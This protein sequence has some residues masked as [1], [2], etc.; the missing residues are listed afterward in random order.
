MAM[1]MK[2]TVNNVEGS[3]RLSHAILEGVNT[4][5]SVSTRTICGENPGLC[6][7]NKGSPSVTE[8]DPNDGEAMAHRT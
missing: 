5:L 6:P 2:E 4:V 1:Y 7:L 8:C 3:R